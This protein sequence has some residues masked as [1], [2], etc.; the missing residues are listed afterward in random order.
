MDDVTVCCVAWWYVKRSYLDCL[1]ETRR[2]PHLYWTCN[3][4]VNASGDDHEPKVC[5]TSRAAAFCY[6]LTA[7]LCLLNNCN[8]FIG[9]LVRTVARN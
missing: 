3:A 5:E 4:E 2:M 7:R 1:Q 9:Y 6:S 8:L